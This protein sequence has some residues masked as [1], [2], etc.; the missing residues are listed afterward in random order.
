MSILASNINVDYSG[1]GSVLASRAAGYLI[2]TALGAVLQNI[3]K[4]HSNGL[5]VLSFLLP[6]IG[7]ILVYL[8]REI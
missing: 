2:A 6:A 4:K 8:Y 1:M 5:L 7:N 3:V